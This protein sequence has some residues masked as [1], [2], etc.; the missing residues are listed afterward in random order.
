M[1]FVGDDWAE[2]HHDIE[3]VN[4]NGRRLAARRLPEGIEGVS[5]LHALISAAMPDQWADLEP[6]EAA[7]RVKIGIETERGPWVAALVAAGY[8]VFAINP[9]S[10]ARYR[11]RHSTSGAKSDPGDAHVLAEIVRLDREH[12]RPVAVDSPTGE[13][14]KLVARS[15]QTLIWERTRHVLRLRSALREYFPA[16]LSAF[17]DLDEPDT[18]ELLAAAPDPDQAARLTKAKIAAAL[19]HAHR[20]NVDVR[21]SMIQAELRTPALRQPPAV[22]AAFAAIA[23]GQVRLIAALNQEIDTLGEVVAEHF[24]RHPDAEIYASQPGLGVIL[25]ARVLAE[26]GDDPRRYADAKARRNYAGTSPITKA[27]GTKKK[28][29]ARHA[30]NDRLADALQRWAFASLRGSPGARAYYDALR[31]RNIGHQAALRQLA[32][33]HVGILHGCLKTRTLYNENTAWGHQNVAAALTFKK[34][35]C[36]PR[37]GRA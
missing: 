2:D 30:R 31:A 35:G 4:E 8:E 19:R 22:Q 18:L 6:G 14:M 1:L 26:F 34:L 13:A 11:E 7:A 20:H 15:H 24:G 37:C 25:G 10:T 28:V 3:I 21:V 16:A 32:N 36:L 17:G 33:R 5:R 9:M 12:H 23:A 27:S 29:L